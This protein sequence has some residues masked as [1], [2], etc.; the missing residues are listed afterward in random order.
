METHA[1]A[2]GEVVEN[3]EEGYSSIE[4]KRRSCMPCR[5]LSRMPLN[6]LRALVMADRTVTV[7]RNS[8]LLVSGCVNGR[9]AECDNAERVFLLQ[10]TPASWC[11]EQLDQGNEQDVYA[12][13]SG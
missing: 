5:L 9:V 3:N 4:G 11:P 12:Q 6:E 13:G 2:I 8:L 1:K 10:L 7:P